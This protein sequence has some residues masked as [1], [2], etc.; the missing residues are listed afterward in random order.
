MLADI[1][2]MALIV[3]IILVIYATVISVWAGWRQQ[4]IKLIS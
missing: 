2:L 1:G 3:A 4:M